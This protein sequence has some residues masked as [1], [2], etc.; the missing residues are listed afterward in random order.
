[1]P[2]IKSDG[3]TK[4]F[5]SK[6][7]VDSLSF[8]VASG[9]VTG[10]LG[11]N[12]AGKSTTMRLIMGLDLPNSGGALLNGKRINEIASPMREVGVLLDAGYVHPTRTARNH[13]WALAA[14]NS[15]PKSRVEEVLSMVGLTEVAGKRVGNFSL[16]MKQRLG[17]AATLLG[18]PSIVILD[19]PANGLDPEGV[20]W[21]R[22][23]LS[24]LADQGR[25]VF[26]S[27]HL[28][29]EMALMAS[30]LVIIGNGRLIA[31]TSVEELTSNS[32]GASVFVRSPN[33]T[34]LTAALVAAGARVSDGEAADREGIVVTGLE[35]TEVGRLAFEKNI[36]LHELSPRT[37][38]LEEAFL[39][40][41]AGFQEY[42]T[43]HHGEVAS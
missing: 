8:E 27:S 2:V 11:P 10:F 18:D 6:T 13:L 1:M 4:A 40:L 14:S 29:S 42:Q 35:A 32:A 24:Y 37:S 7:V 36:E 31:E 30:A 9:V 21:I 25:T 26:V 43:E 38:T 23:F 5:G 19:E 17:I 28:L 33:L 22:N 34:E 15:I 3:L 41:T 20:H 39:E 16:G 12:G